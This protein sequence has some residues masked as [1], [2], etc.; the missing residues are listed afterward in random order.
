MIAHLDIDAFFAAV[1][2]HRRPELRGRPLIVGGDPSG[3]G[4]VA[5]ASYAA[6]ESGI[7][8]AMSCAEARRRCPDAVFVPPDIVRYRAWS[9][10]VWEVLR[11]VSDAVEVVGL[12]EGYLAIGGAAPERRARALQQVVRSRMRLSC[13]LG[14][15]TA[16]VVAKV[17]SDRDKPGGI[18][19]VPAGTEADFL[20]PLPLRALPGIGPR[21]EERLRAAGLTRIGDVAALEDDHELVAGAWGAQM[22][23]R[24]RGIDPRP[25]ASEPAERQ[26]VSAERTFAEDIDDTAELERRGREMAA[27]VADRL[28]ERDRAGTTVTVKLRFPDFSTIT[29]SETLAAP[30][31]AAEEIWSVA[32]RL[33]ALARDERPE[34]LR[35]LGVGVSG[36]GRPRQ[37]ALFAP[38]GPPVSGAQPDS[39]PRSGS[40]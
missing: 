17:A 4:V 2:L 16:K 6:R 31:I 26:S 20:A 24:A 10:R 40:R 33:L 14:V 1:E 23:A 11:Q 25:V 36:F 29:R 19:F 34:P 30:T 18:T 37:L 35:L 13:S 15:A 12:D 32:A 9:A 3:R 7:R 39:R 22:H 27:R 21:T 5:T 38:S 28:A 8:S